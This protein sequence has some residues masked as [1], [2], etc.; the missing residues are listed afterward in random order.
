MMLRKS[1]RFYRNIEN[2]NLNPVTSRPEQIDCGP[3]ESYRLNESLINT[4]VES[5]NPE[6]RLC[7]SMMYLQD[8]S[9]KDI[10]GITGYTLNQ[11]KSHIQNGKRNLKNYLLS[12]YD[13]FYP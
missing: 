1:P 11:V 7:V 5:L 10:A 9:Y 12:R 4:A 2:N 8:R 13:P 6:Q 3:E